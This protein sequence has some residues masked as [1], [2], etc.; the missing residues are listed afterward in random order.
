MAP[1]PVRDLLRSD[2][3]LAIHVER[4]IDHLELGQPF[5][6]ALDPALLFAATATKRNRQCRPAIVPSRHCI[7]LSLGNG[8]LAC[9]GIDGLPAEQDGLAIRLHSGLLLAVR[10][11][12][13]AEVFDECE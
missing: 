5:E 6:L 2:L 10:A 8:D 9:F 12:I 3:A 7:D 1:K 4:Q 11:P 13:D